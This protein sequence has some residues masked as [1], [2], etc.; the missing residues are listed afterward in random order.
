[1]SVYG[2]IK[3]LRDTAGNSYWQNRIAAQLLFVFNLSDRL[4]LSLEERLAP[5]LSL[6]LRSKEEKGALVRGDVLFA[7][8]SLCD[9]SP[10]VK[11]YTAHMVAHAHIDMNWMWGYPE[12][13]S[14]TLDTMR[15]M[16]DFMDKY[17]EFTFSQSQASVYEIV[18]EYDPPMLER[19]KV[20]I[21]EGR[22]E[23]TAGTWVEHDKN[24]AGTEAQVRQVT[25]AKKYLSD[26]LEID[27][28]SLCIDFEPDT[29]GHPENTPE[30]LSHC[31][32]KYYYH[33]R[34]NGENVI[35]NW[36]A[37]SGGELLVYRDPKWYNDG[38]DPYILSF[39]PCIVC[40]L[41]IK[42][43][44][45]VY[46]VGDHGGGPTRKDIEAIIDMKTWPLYPNMKFSMYK[47]FF[48]A[49][50]PYRESFDTVEGEQNFIF[51]GC[52]TSQSKIKKAN[53]ILESHLYDGECL[54]ALSSAV[55]GKDSPCIDLS[56][57]WRGALFNQFHDILPGSGVAQTVEHAMGTFQNSLA[58]TDAA[59]NR[60]VRAISD[61]TD[62]SGIDLNEE[63][64]FTSEGA[65][66]GYYSSHNTGYI[67]GSAE[68]GLGSKRIVQLFNTTAFERKEVNKIVLFDFDVDLCDVIVKDGNGNPLQFVPG[69][70]KRHF[71][72]HYITEIYVFVT[73]LPMGYETVIIEKK[74]DTEKSFSFPEGPN[75]RIYS[76]GDCP[77][78]LENDLI[79]ATFEPC[80]YALVSLFDKKRNAEL[81][82][83]VKGEFEL[84]YET[85]RRGES[86]WTVGQYMQKKSLNREYKTKFLD[87]YSNDLLTVLRYAVFFERSE[88]EVTHTLR[89]GSSVIE[90]D[91]KLDWLEASVRPESV[92]SVRFALKTVD[93]PQSY[94]YGTPMGECIREPIYYDVPAIKYA[95][96]NGLCVICPEKYG[97]RGYM[98]E[99]SLNLIRSS[100]DPDPY[101][102]LGRH[103]M[104]FFFGASQYSE[105]SAVAAEKLSHP[106]IPVSAK[107]HKGTLPLSG[108]ILTVEG[109]RVSSVKAAESGDGIVVRLYNTEDEEKEVRIGAYTEIEKAC[110]CDGN[111]KELCSLIVEK[112]VVVTRIGK[113]AMTAIKLDFFQKGYK[114][115]KGG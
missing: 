37:P 84:S 76:F 7:E 46:G 97:Y 29:F 30:I 24:L 34:G 44:L 16:L 112:G 66:A 93:A 80:T 102:D 20:R 113:R 91:V 36:K 82:G 107:S 21:K 14:A 56:K 96:G 28:D 74:A 33:C 18:K 19:I 105:E 85:L 111:E 109:A 95:Y 12:T 40:D 75:P 58:G 79:R 38:I 88:M 49:I 6:L 1:M 54:S 35:Y 69:E 71:W 99:L 8:E 17:P 50:E 81:C 48:E 31:G 65:G 5:V 68:R 89:K 51:S 52:Y 104:K 92:P 87:F 41:G 70:T 10:M 39:M 26:L 73:V 86:S 98:G 106:L 90:T 53:S 61:A 15:T 47:N 72:Q 32:I 114:D 45:N 77:R 67:A 55:L 83:G 64:G 25:Q 101:P 2:D 60:A 13:V 59:I 115:E 22:W 110:L 27:G 3:K 4:G 57:E 42:D 11:E 63:G 23:V 62:T 9:L 94:T 103:D 108:S 100:S 43:M 78:V